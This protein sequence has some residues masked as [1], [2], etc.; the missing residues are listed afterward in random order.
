MVLENGTW[1]MVTRILDR[2]HGM[3][4]LQQ[5][6]DNFETLLKSGADDDLI[7]VAGHAS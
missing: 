1:Q 3:T 2:Y 4:L 5:L 6:C 7:R